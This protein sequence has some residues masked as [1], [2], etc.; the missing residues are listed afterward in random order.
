V[1]TVSIHG[2]QVYHQ[3]GSLFKFV[4]DIGLGFV[5]CSYQSVG[6]LQFIGTRDGFFG[7][8]NKV[9]YH[10][11]ILFNRAFWRPLASAKLWSPLYCAG[12][13]AG[14][15]GGYGTS[16]AAFTTPLH[17]TAR[18]VACIYQDSC[19]CPTAVP[20][21]QAAPVTTVAE[22]YVLFLK[23]AGT[24]FRHEHGQIHWKNIPSAD[25]VIVG[26]I[27]CNPASPQL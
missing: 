22:Q 12:Q 8:L 21:A 16:M 14:H 19:S 9:A 17:W 23:S 4:Y 24:H 18:G 26:H 15:G 11:S 3:S 6:G 5:H 25:W 27:K 10:L 2:I 7:T 1:Y 13:V 20:T